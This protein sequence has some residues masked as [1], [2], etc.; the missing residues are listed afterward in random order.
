M[1]VTGNKKQE[2]VN[3]GRPAQSVNG[4]QQTSGGKTTVNPYT[5][6]VGVSQNTGQHVAQAQQGYQQG[7][8]VTA[9]QNVWQQIQQ[10]QPGEYQSP[11]A[12]MLQNIMQQIQNPQEFKYEFNGDALFKGYADLYQQK[13][14]QGMMDA[15]GQAAG[16]T[17]GFG[18]SYA[19]ALGQQQYQ[20]NMLGLYDKGL[21]LYDRA[22]Q[23]YDQQQNNLLNQ[24][25]VLNQQ[26]QTAYDRYRDEYNDWVNQ[27]QTA[28][29]H[30]QDAQ[31]FD[32]NLYQ[33]DLNYWTGLAQ[34][35]NQAYQTEQQRQDAVEQYKQQYAWQQCQAIL[36]NGHM[37]SAALLAAAGL[38]AED[39]AA[40]MAQMEVAAPSGGS[41][42]S[43]G[44][45]GDTGSTSILQAQIPNLQNLASHVNSAIQNAVNNGA[46]SGLTS[47]NGSSATTTTPQY[48]YTPGSP[49]NSGAMSSTGG[50]PGTVGSVNT[51]T[52]NIWAGLSEKK[53][54][55]NKN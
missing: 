12:N 53:K 35:E 24:Y 55:S 29:G 28:Y 40:M 21:E 51:G 31:S 39:A 54:R 6:M 23:A 48:I 11:Y 5:G 44:S 1:A 14:K 38:S 13:A 34:I 43:P 8:N 25:N 20:Q 17:G 16:L 4:A 47:G 3:G 15:M 49:N 10:Q 41:G 7:Q 37:P 32:Y 19:Q 9:A 18:N 36:A 30:W 22:R 46:L 52:N 26:E 42:G 33:N 50:L 45:T 27:E 2:L